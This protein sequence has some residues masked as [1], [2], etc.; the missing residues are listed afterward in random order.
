VAVEQSKDK[1]VEA[2]NKAEAALKKDRKNYSGTDSGV[3]PVA[4]KRGIARQGEQS[5]AEA[6]LMLKGKQVELGIVSLAPGGEGV[7]KDFPV[8]V[9]INKA[10][11]GDRLLVEIYDNRRTFAKG[12]L[13][14]VIEASKDRI[15]PLCKLFKVCG[16]CQWM[17]L[18]YAAQL[19]WKRALI[20]QS[21]RHIGGPELGNLLSQVLLPAVPAANQFGYR[22]KV[23][24]PVRNPNKSKRLLAGYFE[25]N[26]H[27]LVNIKHCPIQP[28]LLDDILAKIKEL[29]EKYNIVAYDEK[30]GHGL[31]RHI[32]MRISNAS[33]ETL[34]T[35]VVNCGHNNMPT[36]LKTVALELMEQFSQIKGV[37]AN[38]NQIKGNR[39]LGEQTVCLAGQDFIEETLRTQKQDFPA[40]LQ[41]GLKFKLSPTSFFQVNTPQTITLLELV[42]QEIQKY[43]LERASA[44]DSKKASSINNSNAITLLDAY[45][46][47]GT[48]A[49]WLAAFV[50]RIIAI[51]SN[52][53]AIKD[54][55]VNGSLN[56]INNVVFQL[57]KVEDYLS[58]LL[59][60]KTAVEIIVLDPPRQG[61][62]PQVIESIIKLQPELIIYISC[63]PVTLARDLRQ[64]LFPPEPDLSS[65]GQIRLEKK[66]DCLKLDFGYKVEKII[67][68]DLFPQ[69]YHIESI[70]VLKRQ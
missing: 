22:N 12:K 66:N 37:C 14:K 36:S 15:D 8:P 32:Q 4:V 42:A 56:K 16:G 46:G 68:V 20:E 27:N 48:I 13:L 52:P 40:I 29:A 38:Y 55:Q 5:E 60:S 34:V 63:N 61:L 10:A 9:F 18:N 58:V 30:T 44:Q 23:Q 47:V 57:A 35:L 69:T 33:Q 7:S 1:C 19:E 28:S 53:Q 3:E 31:L 70:T 6:A 45:A 39:I 21:L 65:D 51:E 54:G 25:V 41:E 26:S 2:N 17:H 49:L 43:L 59:K 67:P 11:P 62:D 64:I 24:L 50:S